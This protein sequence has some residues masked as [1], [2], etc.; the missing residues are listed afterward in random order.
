MWRRKSSQ[1]DE[2]KIISASD[3]S[4]VDSKLEELRNKLKQ[5]EEKESELKAM[6]DL[7]K[8]NVVDKS[9]EKEKQDV[10]DKSEKQ[11]VV[12]REI[13]LSLLNDKLNYLISLVQAV[14]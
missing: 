5:L 6:R 2:P 4:P 7:E 10:A 9:Y 1:P 8:Q 13:N 14:K 12:E 11:V 3:S